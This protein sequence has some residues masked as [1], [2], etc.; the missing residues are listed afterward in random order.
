LNRALQRYAEL[1]KV[2]GS[3]ILRVVLRSRVDGCL[4]A[5]LFWTLK[6]SGGYGTN[7]IDMG[8]FD[9]DEKADYNQSLLNRA[10]YAALKIHR[11]QCHQST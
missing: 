2:L 7:F 3:L 1:W 11:W 6:H 10:K 5:I 9:I 8:N 4:A